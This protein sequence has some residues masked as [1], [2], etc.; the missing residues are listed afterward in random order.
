MPLQPGDYIYWQIYHLK[1]SLQAGWEGSYQAF[2]TSSCATKL[3]GTDSW[4]HIF[5][6]KRASTLDWSIERPADLK[7]TLKQ[8]SEDKLH[9][10]QDKKMT[11][12]DTLPKMLDL[13]RMIIYVFLTSS[14]FTYRSNVFLSRAWSY[15]SFQN[16]SNCWVCCQLP[17]S[18]TSWLLWWIS[19]FQGTDWPALRKLILEESKLSPAQATLDITRW[20]P[21]TWPVNNTCSD[22]GHIYEFSFRV[23]QA[24]SEQEAKFQLKVVT[25]HLLEGN[26]PRLWDWFL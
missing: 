10:H 11:S 17:M 2:L 21:L 9:S 1:D 19:H 14:T 20:D 12:A 18:S 26:L 13:I 4:I 23:T 5:H 16:Q 8:Y 6:L 24:Q 15:A 22:P 25:S 7:L 3:K